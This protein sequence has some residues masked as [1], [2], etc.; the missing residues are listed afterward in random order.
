MEIYLAVFGENHPNVAM[1]YNNIGGVYYN[2]GNYDQALEYYNKALKIYLAVFGENHPDVAM[3][4]SN[5]GFNYYNQ[6]LYYEAKIN[7]AKAIE[8]GKNFWTSEETNMQ[9]LLSLLYRS[10]IKSSSPET[11]EY[12]SFMSDKAFTAKVVSDET[13]ASQQGMSEEYYLL[14]FADWN[15]ENTTDL[16]YKNNELKDKPKDIVVMKDGVIT[17]HHFEDTIGMQLGIKFVSKE[18]K[19]KIT[20]AYHKW[21]EEHGNDE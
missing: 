3:S 17:K 11:D 15:F 13:P 1:N 18:E 21:K 19:Q 20:E 8:T 6:D 16:F 14:E 2:Q 9:I 4:Y 10:L 12:S 7:F 5:I